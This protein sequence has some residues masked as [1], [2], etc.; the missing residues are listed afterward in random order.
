MREPTSI[1]V[2]G[3]LMLRLATKGYQRIVQADEFEVRF[4]GAEANVG[5]S[6]VNYGMDAYV[7]SK[8]P[9]SDLGQAC[10]NYLQR[11]G[12][13]TENIVRGGERLGILYTE[14]GYSQR[15]SKVIYD[16]RESS[17]SELKRGELDWETILKGKSWFHF[18]GTAPAHG[19]SVLE[20]LLEGLVTA[21]RMG[22]P[23]SADY[24]YRAKLWSREEARRTM[25]QIMEY[26]DIG[27]GN[28]EDCE[29]MFGIV[30]E[31]TN[32]EQGTMKTASYHDVAK[33]MVNTFGL[34]Y[35]AITLR[36]S[37]SAN[38]NGWS[39]IIHDGTQC[40]QSTHYTVDVVDRVGAGDSFSGALIYCLAAQKSLQY[41]LDFAVAASCLKHTIPGDFN[42]VS[43]QDVINLMEGKGTGR[44]QR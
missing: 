31:G 37:H 23:I 16:R 7:A 43:T 27:I 24:N 4:T 32:L 21:R 29:A 1:V 35:Q 41:A 3:E 9:D 14:T 42:L 11:Y 6:C 25:K 40:Y 28:E 20:V 44:I 12:L 15:A 26:V 8:V 38:R 13:N 10:I 19:E 2:F 17:F 33:N 34:R 5:V 39:A 30:A 36:D 18:C 22:I